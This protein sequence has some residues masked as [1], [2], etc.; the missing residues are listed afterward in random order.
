M[1]D[2]DRI[3]TNLRTLLIL[4]VLGKSD[5]PMTA[6]QINEQLGL[7]KQTVHRLCVTLEENGFLT[8]PGN[9]KKYQVGRRL[10]DLGSGLL[11]NSR[12][13]VA[14]H[15]ILKEV[16]DSI[17]ETVN[18]AVPGNEGMNYLDRVETDWPFRIQLPIGT[19][20]PFH[21]TASGKVFL[22]SLTRKKRETLVASIYLRSMTRHTHSDPQAL[23]DELNKIR[24]QGYSL[25]QEEF[26][27]GMV[28]I[29]VPVVDPRGRFVAGLACHGPTQR[30]SLAEVIEGKDVLL[31]AAAKISNVL[32]QQE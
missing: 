3:P 13:H 26:L 29:A 21:C 10:R 14:R 17:G 23:L 18:Y 20:V 24:G 25:D 6:T 1:P 5:Q 7:P 27:E 12:D 9:S 19:S 28:A 22:A 4:E 16:A 31:S 2:S 30:M 8:R 11:H 32:F 15:Q